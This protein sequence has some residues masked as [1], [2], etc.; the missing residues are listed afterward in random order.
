M[1]NLIIFFLLSLL[2]LASCS[3]R[4]ENNILPEIK[5]EMEADIKKSFAEFLLDNID[6]NYSNSNIEVTDIEERQY[7]YKGDLYGTY[8]LHFEYSFKD[9]ENDVKGAGFAVYSHDGSLSY[10]SG[11]DG[12]FVD[13]IKVNGVKQDSKSSKYNIYI[14]KWD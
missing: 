13:D 14:R 7:E 9:G 1:K 2:S 5:Q 12:I 10:V 11:D 6:S 3:H 8:Q 4:N